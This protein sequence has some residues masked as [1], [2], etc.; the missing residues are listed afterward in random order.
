MVN[1]SFFFKKNIPYQLSI[2][3][4]MYFCSVKKNEKKVDKKWQRK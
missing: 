2:L 1:N 4:K 3:K